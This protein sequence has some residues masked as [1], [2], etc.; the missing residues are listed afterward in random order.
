VSA[1]GD[2]VL[3]FEHPFGGADD[4]VSVVIEGGTSASTPEAAAAAAVVLQVARLTGDTSLTNNPL[5]VRSFLESS[6]T[7]PPTVPQS[8]IPLHIG[9][10]ID[11]GNAVEELLAAHGR[12]ASPG[13][14][15][16]AVAQRQQASALGGSITTVTDPTNIPLTGRLSDALITIA[17]DW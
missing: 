12:P 14:A 5:A 11:V 7:P 10:Q 6:G 9:P 3:S 1:P 15:R 8:E 16:V 2:N 4:A 17:P 13:V